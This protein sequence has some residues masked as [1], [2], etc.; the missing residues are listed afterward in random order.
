M[1]N[2]A[3]LDDSLIQHLVSECALE[4]DLLETI[5]N[6]LSDIFDTHSRALPMP[7]FRKP[8]LIRESSNCPSGIP[9]DVLGLLDVGLIYH[10][11]GSVQLAVG[12]YIQAIHAW[13]KNLPEAHTEAQVFRENLGETGRN[14][15]VGVKDAQKCVVSSDSESL[16]SHYFSRPCC[17][18]LVGS[19]QSV[20]SHQR[21]R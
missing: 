9:E 20:S 17:D 21:S 5:Y 10:N 16:S 4:P 8:Q 11:Q 12:T 14:G 13:L 7:T 19:R 2:A 1:L 6:D 15:G 3:A 18:H